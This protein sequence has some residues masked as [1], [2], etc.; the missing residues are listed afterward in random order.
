LE[1]R[2]STFEFEEEEVARDTSQSIVGSMPFKFFFKFSRPTK[3]EFM[4]HNALDLIGRAW[5]GLIFALKE[6][7]GNV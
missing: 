3:C 7:S 4:I 1:V 6:T 2:P 5:G